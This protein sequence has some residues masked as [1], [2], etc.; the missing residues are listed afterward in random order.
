MRSSE[1][2]VRELVTPHFFHDT[3][4]PRQSLASLINSADVG[5]ELEHIEDADRD[6]IKVAAAD[7]ITNQVRKALWYPLKD[8][9][10][11]DFDALR[12]SQPPK[13][14]DLERG[15]QAADCIGFTYASSYFL[16]E[17]GIEHWIAFANSHAGLVID[18]DSEQE[19][20]FIDPLSSELDQNIFPAIVGFSKDHVRQDLARFKRSAIMLD[21]N[22]VIAGSR[23][24]KMNPYGASPW[25]S[26]KTVNSD[27]SIRVGEERSP[28]I[29]MSLFPSEIGREVLE[30]WSTFQH[31][32]LG[33]D[34][35]AAA[36]GLHQMGN[37][38]PQMDARSSHRE[39][40][41][42]VRNLALHGHFDEASIAVEDYFDSFRFIKDS[43]FD[44]AKGDC[45][46]TIALVSRSPYF[47][48]LA[49]E[50]YEQALEVSS[51]NLD[52]ITKKISKLATR[53]GLNET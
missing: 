45:M 12:V 51:I 7:F 23:L 44:E 16:E 13:L 15:K 30:G 29:I 3:D 19:V 27:Q 47:A 18:T 1:V 5:F 35:H 28:R 21:S 8:G 14:E 33:K 20:F 40:K 39:L 25:L 32:V 41:W 10:R 9:K 48:R 22:R 52:P 50:A 2:L 36:D 26:H 46:R 49:I 38:F 11:N 6:C 4:E 42:V 53:S 17:Q 34:F 24:L 37:N 31:G 43:R